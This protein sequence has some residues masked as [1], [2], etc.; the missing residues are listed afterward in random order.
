MKYL[1]WLG[2]HKFW[3]KIL[4]ILDVIPEEEDNIINIEWKNQVNVQKI[5]REALEK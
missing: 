3:M 1:W 5:H 4:N 2:I